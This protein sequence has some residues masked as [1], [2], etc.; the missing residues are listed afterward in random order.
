MLDAGMS[1]FAAGALKAGIAN[2]AV[3]A[4]SGQKINFKEALT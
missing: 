1:P 3:Q 2:L 4:V